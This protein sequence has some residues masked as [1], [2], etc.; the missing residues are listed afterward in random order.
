M[1]AFGVIDKDL[2]IRMEAL[3]MSSLCLAAEFGI[4]PLYLLRTYSAQVAVTEANMLDLIFLGLGA[5]LF[6]LM[7]LYAR[8]CTRL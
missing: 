4:A 6:A 7:A 5:V 8:A 3:F 2:R 1:A